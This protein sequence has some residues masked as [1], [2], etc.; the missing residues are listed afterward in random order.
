MRVLSFKNFASEVK[1]DT[2]IDITYLLTNYEVL[3]EF[4]DRLR[5]LV[6]V[7]FTLYNYGYKYRVSAIEKDGMVT[8][9]SNLDTT[10]LVKARSDGYVT[11]NNGVFIKYPVSMDDL[12]YIKDGVLEKIKGEYKVRVPAYIEYI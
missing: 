4:T 5:F 8:V 11:L 1:R 2:G 9:S 3:K 10:S 7:N 6:G 12:E